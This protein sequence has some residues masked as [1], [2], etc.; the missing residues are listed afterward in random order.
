MRRAPRPGPGD[1]LGPFLRRAEHAPLPAVLRGDSGRTALRLGEGE[2][3]RHE[4]PVAH[5]NP[6][7]P[8]DRHRDVELVH[9]V[10]VHADAPARIVPEPGEPGAHRVP[11]AEQGAA[12]PYRAGIELA[13][14]PAM[15][16]EDG[17]DLRAQDGVER[18]GLVVVQS[19]RRARREAVQDQRGAQ[20]VAHDGHHLLGPL[21]E[22]LLA[23]HPGRDAQ[24]DDDDEHRHPVGEDVDQGDPREVGQAAAACDPRRG[25]GGE[26]ANRSAAGAGGGGGG[27]GRDGPGRA[28]HGPDSA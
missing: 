1:E 14:E 13:D 11:A 7:L 5:R 19:G 9:I 21:D 15:Q 3:M 23:F 18:R 28:A 10:D 22:A 24:H 16:L 25:G 6:V 12:R 4:V 27:A 26:P 20:P 2:E 17:E 8:E